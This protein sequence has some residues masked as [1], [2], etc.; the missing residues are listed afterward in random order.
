MRQRPQFRNRP[1][2]IKPNPPTFFPISLATIWASPTNVLPIGPVNKPIAPVNKWQ[3][4]AFSR[5][6]SDKI[7]N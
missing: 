6:N 4:G 3:G 1:A 2:A 7:F 5:K